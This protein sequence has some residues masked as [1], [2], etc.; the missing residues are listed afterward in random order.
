M[1]RIPTN[2]RQSNLIDSEDPMGSCASL[3]VIDSSV[4]GEVGASKPIAVASAGTFALGAPTM[5]AGNGL[6]TDSKVSSQ[7]AQDFARATVAGP[8]RTRSVVRMVGK[9]PLWVSERSLNKGKEF[10]VSRKQQARESM[11]TV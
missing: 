11:D 4:V 2:P 5:V 8:T 10:P 1:R 3:S 6:D 7:V 9:D